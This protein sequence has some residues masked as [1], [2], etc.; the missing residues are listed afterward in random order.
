MTFSL[1]NLPLQGHL[2]V[3]PC[4]FFL[5]LF[6]ISHSLQMQQ[7]LL[8]S[9]QH[10]RK[11][12]SVLVVGGAGGSSESTSLLNLLEITC[13]GV[14]PE[15]QCQCTDTSVVCV[16]AQLR[17]PESLSLMESFPKLRQLTFHGNNFGHLPDRALSNS[18]RLEQLTNLNLSANYLVSFHAKAFFGLSNVERLDL[19]ENEII[20]DK[21]MT[22]L[23]LPF[24]KLKDLYLRRAFRRSITRLFDS[25]YL[26]KQMELLENLFRDSKLF[27]LE[28][29]DLSMN[30]F[31]FIRPTL[32]CSIDKLTHVFLS[33]NHL[34]RLELDFNCI[35]RL[36]V[37]DLRDN[38][39]VALNPG[40]YRF[41]SRLPLN[42]MRLHGNPF[43]CLCNSSF[44]I[45]WLNTTDKVIDKTNLTCEKA[46]PRVYAK[47]QLISVPVEKL[48]CPKFL[49]NQ[50]SR[51]V[52]ESGTWTEWVFGFALIYCSKWIT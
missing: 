11:G 26:E 7:Q 33:W 39:F 3:W 40:F 9:Q 12:P 32:F 48:E 8:S 1:L 19:S 6:L 37:L 34:R 24:R 21:T 46:W 41:A 22:E 44:Y 14:L 49:A 52:R 42:S 2:R 38:H 31:A 50:G 13:K 51:L 47:R 10:Q 23:F 17:S 35:R 15:P 27:E 29:L 28:R 43:E 4:T 25:S 20:L 16:N 18:T 5:L 36:K 30:A 45:N